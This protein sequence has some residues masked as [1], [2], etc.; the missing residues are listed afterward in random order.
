MIDIRFLMI[1]DGLKKK[2]FC[3]FSLFWKKD[4]EKFFG[5]SVI[6]VLVIVFND[7]IIYIINM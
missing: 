5:V 4:K 7:L 2:K 6:G 1:F 3:E